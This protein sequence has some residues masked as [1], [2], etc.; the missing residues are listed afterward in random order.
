MATVVLEA[1]WS[2]QM[3]TLCLELLHRLFA[4]DTAQEQKPIKPHA[5]QM[6]KSLDMVTDPIPNSPGTE[7]PW[8]QPLTTF[9]ELNPKSN[10]RCAISN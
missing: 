3:N 2:N 6:C 1:Y 8:Q 5:L 10:D 4:I 9:W 7:A